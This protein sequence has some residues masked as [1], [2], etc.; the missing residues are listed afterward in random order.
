MHAALSSLRCGREGGRVGERERER[1]M[2]MWAAARAD[3]HARV[4]NHSNPKKE[5]RKEPWPVRA[6]G[7]TF[8][9]VVSLFRCL[10][11]ERCPC[12]GILRKTYSIGVS[13]ALRFLGQ[14]HT[15]MCFRS[16]D[17]EHPCVHFEFPSVWQSDAFSNTSL[18]GTTF[19]K[20]LE[21]WLSCNMSSFER[22]S[23]PP[24]LSSTF[25]SSL[26]ARYPH[27]PLLHWQG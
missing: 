19:T 7:L 22:L 27:S 3:V 23:P 1:A 11:A 17:D 16:V 9:F 13:Y 21:P 8:H 4:I 24:L 5:G 25:S 6:T 12:V 15:P 10:E 2:A 14:R 18:H 20:S 26:C